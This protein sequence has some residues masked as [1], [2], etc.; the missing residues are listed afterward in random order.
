MN[1][2]NPSR[3]YSL[4]ELIALFAK[5]FEGQAAAAL[6]YAATVAVKP[7]IRDLLIEHSRGLLSRSFLTLCEKFAAGALDERLLTA[8]GTQYRM[9]RS[10]PLSEQKTFLENGVLLLEAD[11]DSRTIPIDEVT[12]EQA[13]QGIGK[14]LA[15][16]RTWLNSRPRTADVKHDYIVFKDRVR[17]LKAP[18]D[19]DR[20]LLASLLQQLS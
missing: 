16:Q 9:L 18:F 13:R 4:E 7:E 12:P 2:S 6:A 8:S 19:L 14:T 20:R 11:G 5:A 10:L 1:N 17:I 3:L 15:Q